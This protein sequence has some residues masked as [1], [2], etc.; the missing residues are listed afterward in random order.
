MKTFLTT[1]VFNHGVEHSNANMKIENMKDGEVVS[2]H[3]LSYMS[4]S[5]TKEKKELWP[6]HQ[7][8]RSKIKKQQ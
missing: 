3:G 2:T 8:F 1:H 6:L 7:R 4:S 5:S